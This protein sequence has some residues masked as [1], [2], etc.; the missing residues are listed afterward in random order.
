MIEMVIG[1][2]A[3]ACLSAGNSASA[4]FWNYI[5]VC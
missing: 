2:I 1:N 3:K 4:N 5:F